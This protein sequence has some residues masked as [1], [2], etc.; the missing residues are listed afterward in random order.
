MPGKEKV[1]DEELMFKGYLR[2]LARQLNLLKK[3]IGDKDF[4]QA[5]LIADELIE[6]TQRS[7]ED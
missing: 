3:A 1:M 5:E 4:V 7:I 2:S 6:D